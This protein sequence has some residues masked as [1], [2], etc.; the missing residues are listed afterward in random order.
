MTADIRDDP[1]TNSVY[2]ISQTVYPVSGLIFVQISDIRPDICPDIRYPAALLS[3]YPVAG[4]ISNSVSSFLQDIRLTL[5]LTG[6][7]V[8]NLIFG[9]SLI[10][11]IMD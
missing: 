2:R 6:Y 3:R 9:T 4:Q 7:Q 8:A 5:Y 11:M 1:N 10:V